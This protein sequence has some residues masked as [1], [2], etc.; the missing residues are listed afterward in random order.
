MYQETCPSTFVN[1]KFVSEFFMELK[2]VGDN[3]ATE[4]LAKIV[5]N[6]EEESYVPKTE[7][8]LV[9]IKTL[10]FNIMLCMHK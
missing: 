1:Y 7:L 4:V 2:K 5:E 10:K 3:N 8:F 6:C 9:C